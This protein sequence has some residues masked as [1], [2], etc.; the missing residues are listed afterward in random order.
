[1]RWKVAQSFVSLLTHSHGETQKTNDMHDT[2]DVRQFLATIGIEK[3]KS[4][5]SPSAFGHA[6]K[7]VTQLPKCQSVSEE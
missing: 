3:L 2:K 5:H 1:M 6:I 4:A 7:T